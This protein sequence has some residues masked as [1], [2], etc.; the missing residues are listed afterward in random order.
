MVR[1]QPPTASRQSDARQPPSIQRR[2]RQSGA[3]H[4]VTPAKKDAARLSYMPSKQILRKPQKAHAARAVSERSQAS[5]QVNPQNTPQ[6]QPHSL[7]RSQRQ[8]AADSGRNDGAASATMRIIATQP[9]EPVTPLRSALKQPSSSEERAAKR[10]RKTRFELPSDSESEGQGDEDDDAAVGDDVGM[11]DMDTPSKKGPVVSGRLGPAGRPRS[12]APPSGASAQA[13]PTER[14]ERERGRSV[15]QMTR[16]R[17]FVPRKSEQEQHEVKSSEQQIAPD[18]H[19]LQSGLD[20]NPTD[21]PRSTQKISSRPRPI[22]YRPGRLSD[23]TAPTSDPVDDAHS[24]DHDS[25]ESYSPSPS[26]TGYIKVTDAALLPSLPLGTVP[27]LPFKPI[28]PRRQPGLVPR[29]ISEIRE[30]IDD[31]PMTIPDESGRGAGLEQIPYLPIDQRPRNA[32]GQFL[33]YAKT[34]LGDDGDARW[35]L[36][37]AD[38]EE[39][40]E[41]PSQSQSQTLSDTRSPSPETTQRYQGQEAWD[42]HQE[43]MMH[44]D[45]YELSQRYEDVVSQARDGDEMLIGGGNG[46][47]HRQARGGGKGKGRLDGQ[48]LSP[49]KEE[50]EYEYDDDEELESDDGKMDV[51]VELTGTYEDDAEAEYAGESELPHSQRKHR[52]K[53]ADMYSRSTFDPDI[54]VSVNSAARSTSSSSDHPSTQTTQSPA[55]SIASLRSPVQQQEHPL[56]RRHLHIRNA[57][58]KHPT[59]AS[60]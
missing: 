51:D 46:Q 31:G 29:P 5:Q 30:P 33:P 16:S 56:A 28:K 55:I 10:A 38:R 49:V 27:P 35:E 9:D 39:I 44:E 54:P 3:S 11:E 50:E 13:Q 48:M 4:P 59:T 26:P 15:P 7:D 36:E 43:G 12:R 23:P 41:F 20:H 40:D 42:S 53:Q 45:E 6:G 24:D 34:R 22:E 14:G 58:A 8:P 18:L 57:A 2:E 60:R 25:T 19:V 1:S 37:E 47:G 17:R 52:H 21:L 32:L